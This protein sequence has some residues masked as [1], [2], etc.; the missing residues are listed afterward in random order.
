MSHDPFG[1]LHRPPF[2]QSLA[3]PGT[4]ARYRLL[5]TSGHCP[6]PPNLTLPSSLSQLNSAEA[7][8]PPAERPLLRNP[9]W[10]KWSQ[11]SQTLIL[12]TLPQG[13]GWKFRLRKKVRVWRTDGDAQVLAL[14]FSRA[15][16]TPLC[17]GTFQDEEGVR[18]HTRV[19]AGLFS[20]SPSQSTWW[21]FEARASCRLRLRMSR[22]RTPLGSMSR[23]GR[24]LAEPSC[25]PQVQPCRLIEG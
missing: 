19:F 5:T 24:H 20:V 3:V 1:Y 9:S 16:N 7:Q 12:V 22:V 15:F 23:Q 6:F 13:L 17:F 2:S 25:E 4:N 10:Y 8:G 11:D 18:L 14:R 21:A